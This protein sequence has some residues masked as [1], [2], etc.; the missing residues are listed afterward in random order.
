M[1]PGNRLA[2]KNDYPLGANPLHISMACGFFTD[3]AVT[4]DARDRL[5]KRPGVDPDRRALHR[6][7]IIT[8]SLYF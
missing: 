5:A 3:D 1:Y 6:R 4:L 2:C 8:Y 7:K